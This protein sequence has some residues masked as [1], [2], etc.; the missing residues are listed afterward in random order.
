MNLRISLAIFS[1]WSGII[2]GANVNVTTFYGK[3]GHLR[4]TDIDGF[5]W[6]LGMDYKITDS[7]SAFVDY[8]N[9]INKSD[10]NST[11]LDVINIGAN[12][13]F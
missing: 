4:K 1:L 8:Q 7:I 10:S 12:Y 3:T 11:K 13:N 2:Y 9:L 5:A 6:G